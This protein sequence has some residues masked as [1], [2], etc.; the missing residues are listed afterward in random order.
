MTNTEDNSLLRYDAL[1][2]VVNIG[3]GNAATSLSQLIEKKVDMDVPTIDILEY[4]EVFQ[5]IRSE[6]EVVRAV[7][8]KLLG[9]EGSFLFVTEPTDAENLAKMMMPEGIDLSQEII[10]SA[11]KELV[12]ILVN[13]FLNAIMKMI[14]VHL[15]TSVP[16]MTEDMFG[17]IISSVYMEEEQ[18]DPEIL[19]L[20]NEFYSLGHKIEGSL[21]FVPKPGVLEK[22]LNQL[23]V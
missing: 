15:I 5:K 6:D 9:G 2:E 19:I 14:D 7:L 10:D 13:S 22:L 11:E 1:Q 16:M 3:G 20:K 12:N 17:S 18:F 4:E 8:M 23:G 21:Y